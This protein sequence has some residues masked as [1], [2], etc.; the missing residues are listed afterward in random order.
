MLVRKACE[1]LYIVA[2]TDR[3]VTYGMNLREDEL[4]E[5]HSRSIHS[6]MHQS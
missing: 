2:A 6:P 5:G 1:L 3:I 4:A